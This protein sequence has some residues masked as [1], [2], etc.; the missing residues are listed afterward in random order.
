VRVPATLCA[1]AAV[2][3]GLS[4][5]THASTTPPKPPFCLRCPNVPPV[6]PGDG[7]I[8]VGQG[9]SGPGGGTE[10]P[11]PAAPAG[12]DPAA[13][14]REWDYTPACAP[15]ARLDPVLRFVSQANCAAA[16]TCGN[17]ARLRYFA[18]FRQVS[19]ATP[20]R[21]LAGTFCL[22]RTQLVRFDPAAA[23]AFA[24][25]YFQHLPL[26]EPG[27]FVQP[28]QS[29]VN[30]PTIFVADPPPDGTFAVEHPP[31]PRITIT[32]RP[33]WHWSFGDGGTARSATP[34]RVFDGRLPTEAAPGYYVAHPYRRP[35]NV[36]ARVSAVWSAT[37][38]IAGFDAVFPMR[39]TVTRTTSRRIP[40]SEGHAVLVD[41]R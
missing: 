34:G 20:W 12:Y 41:N 28:A 35:G 30:L 32:A 7:G 17:P 3:A 25:W 13:P 27:M 36:T 33:V 1:M 11:D 18:A 2:L 8:D 40:I 15:N 16:D 4:P 6:T 23:Q 26:P 24:R 14:R 37:Y 19:P 9:A 29:L 38:T 31:F 5:A 21:R 39:G 22:G 10:G